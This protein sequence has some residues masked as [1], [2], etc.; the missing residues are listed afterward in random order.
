[1]TSRDVRDAPAGTQIPGCWRREGV[2]SSV[3]LSVLVQGWELADLSS[4]QQR[5]P[6][7]HS[8]LPLQTQE[9]G[10]TEH[11]GLRTAS[12]PIPELISQLNPCSH[13]TIHELKLV[14]AVSP[15]PQQVRTGGGMG[16]SY[17]PAAPVTCAT[18]AV[19]DKI[20]KDSKQGQQ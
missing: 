6:W 9:H 15:Q 19:T 17:T 10:T 20:S 14:W 3:S 16:A 12:S 4:R 7:S 11:P 5:R 2:Q 13:H 8:P 18:K 1:M